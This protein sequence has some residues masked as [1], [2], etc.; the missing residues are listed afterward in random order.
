MGTYY[1][2][3]EKTLADAP[4]VPQSNNKDD[5]FYTHGEDP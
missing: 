4:L 3:P 5:S 2:D 1:E